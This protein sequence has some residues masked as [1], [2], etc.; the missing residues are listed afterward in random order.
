MVISSD[1]N[2]RFKEFVENPKKFLRETI[3]SDALLMGAM[4]QIENHNV[5]MAMSGV[6]KNQITKLIESSSVQQQIQASGNGKQK[7]L[8]QA[9]QL[10]G[11]LTTYR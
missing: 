6:A 10:M 11:I 4:G 2:K 1:R 3:Q 8:F 5:C 9:E 7:S